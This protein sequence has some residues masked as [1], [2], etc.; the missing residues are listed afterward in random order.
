MSHFWFL[1]NEGITTA[2]NLKTEKQYKKFIRE[3][4]KTE[5]KCSN[6]G[7]QRNI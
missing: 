3:I 7:K 5:M 6:D 2:E 4:D 1:Q